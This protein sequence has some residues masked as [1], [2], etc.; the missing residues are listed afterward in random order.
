LSVKPVRPPLMSRRSLIAAATAL[1]AAGA[2]SNSAAAQTAEP[3]LPDAAD[4]ITRMMPQ[5]APRLAFRNLQGQSLTLA[6]YAGHP[7]LVNLWATWCGPCIAELPSFAALA[8]K[9]EA[10]GI[11]ILPISIDL[12][13]AAVVQ[14]F[15]ARNGI[16]TLPIL[17]DPDGN[18]LQALKT[19][20]IPVTLVINAAGQLVAR[21]DGAA[22]WDT[23]RM[24]AFLQGLKV[25]PPAGAGAGVVPL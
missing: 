12:T 19:N 14:P 25:K 5:V 16:T 2:W 10:S 9:L 24:R 20:S 8:P 13:G 18:N 23:P 6:D 22:N 3:D 7:L 17:L 1:A 11:R 4:A 15:Y 21:C